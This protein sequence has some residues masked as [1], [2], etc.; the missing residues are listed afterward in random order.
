[1]AIS[2]QGSRDIRIGVVIP[3]YRV[4]KHILDVIASIPATADKIYIVDDACPDKTGEYV[5]AHCRDPRLHVLYHPQ[6]QGVGG[7]VITGWQQA[8]ADGCDIVAKIDGD[9]QMDGRLLPRFVLPIIHGHADYTKG[10]RFYRP[11]SLHK[12]PAGR[13]IGNAL[14]SFVSKI[15]SGYWHVFD[16]L[17]GYTC[18]SAAVLRLLPLDKISRRYFFESDMLFRLNTLQALVVDI[19]MQSVY[20]DER[21]H[22]FFSRN[23]LPFAGGY[24]KN[25]F[26]RIAY[27]YF[28]RDFSLASLEL[29]FGLFFFLFG[30]CFGGYYWRLSIVTGEPATAGT[31]MVAALPL[32]V[33]FQLL[34]SFLNYDM[35]ARP[36]RAITPLIQS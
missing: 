31:V 26:K 28:L 15:S 1:M 20:A 9:G 5:A 36:T 30:L 24:L 19:P 13:L 14:L 22:L 32:I 6:N 27:N 21:S 33:G 11:E 17:N 4:T 3:C 35:S 12:M 16:P 23:A 34:M 8:L 29:V 18:V 7:A 25:F 2:H 10:N